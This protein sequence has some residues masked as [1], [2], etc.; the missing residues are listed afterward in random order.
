MLRIEPATVTTEPN[1]VAG[2]AQVESK[3]GVIVD[4]V[5]ARGL[6]ETVNEENGVPALI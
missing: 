1:V 2:F 4:A 6:K 5:C 3:G